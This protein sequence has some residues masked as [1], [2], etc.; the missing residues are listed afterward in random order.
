MA[1]QK[2][3]GGRPLKFKTVEEL[4]AAIDEYFD[5]CDNRT[6]KVWKEK[7]QEELLI[8]DPAPYTMSGLARRLGIS[9]RT[10]V[11]YTHKKKFFPTIRDARARVEEDV[12]TRLM[13]TR[14]ERGAQFNLKNNFGWVD[15]NET[16]LTTKG[17]PIPL[18]GGITKDVQKDNSAE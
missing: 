14:N 11:N 16:D 7:T 18:L 1:E 9:R 12:E 13:E 10:L 15:K 2:N 4:Q 6:R 17:K 5:Y 8:S 3:K